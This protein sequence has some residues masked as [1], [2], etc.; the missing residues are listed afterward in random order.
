[1]C[2]RDRIREID[3]DCLDLKRKNSR[4]TESLCISRRSTHHCAGHE[5][6]SIPAK[7]EVGEFHCWNKI[8]RFQG[9]EACDSRSDSQQLRRARVA[10]VKREVHVGG[11]DDKQIRKGGSEQAKIE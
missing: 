5:E 8:V 1:M 11:L 2:I 7:A 6:L 3:A 10:G 4:D 9:I